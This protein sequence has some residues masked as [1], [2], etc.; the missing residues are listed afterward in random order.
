[1]KKP[2]LGLG[3][4]FDILQFESIRNGGMCVHHYDI[5]R[6]NMNR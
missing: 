5:R 2:A 3:T 1:M 4:G 6:V